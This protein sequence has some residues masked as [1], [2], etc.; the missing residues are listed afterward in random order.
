VADICT[1]L[2]EKLRAT[3]QLLWCKHRGLNTAMVGL[4]GTGPLVSLELEIL[5]SNG[6]YSPAISEPSSSSATSSSYDHA[7]EPSS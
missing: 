4:Q 3:E 2:E 5:N 6:E 7:G 1:T